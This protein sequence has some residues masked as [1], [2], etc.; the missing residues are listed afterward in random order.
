MFT[1]A[2]IVV[3]SFDFAQRVRATPA[4]SPKSSE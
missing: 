4:W 2:D 1:A 3:A